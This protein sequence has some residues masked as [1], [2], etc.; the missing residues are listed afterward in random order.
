MKPTP[1]KTPAVS[2]PQGKPD[3]STEHLSD[4]AELSKEYLK[5]EA[6]EFSEEELSA[7]L[8]SL[9]HLS[10]QENTK[11]S[12][13]HAK[14]IEKI[15]I[16]AFGR[17]GLAIHRSQH[18]EGG[19]GAAR[20]ENTKFSAAH[21]SSHQG[22]EGIIVSQ[23]SNEITR[24]KAKEEER[25]G[26]EHVLKRA[27]DNLKKRLELA[28][29]RRLKNKAIRH[30]SDAC[31]AANPAKALKLIAKAEHEFEALGMAYSA[32]L[33]KAIGQHFN[34]CLNAGEKNKDGGPIPYWIWRNIR[35]YE[36]SMKEAAL[37]EH[38]KK[39]NEAELFWELKAAY[40][41]LDEAAI[42]PSSKI[43]WAA[44]EADCR[45]RSLD[46]YLYEAKI[47]VE[48]G[49]FLEA[50]DAYKKNLAEK[51]RER[52]TQDDYYR[53][54]AYLFAKGGVKFIEE[55][56]LAE[57]GNAYM[58]ASSTAREDGEMAKY[59]A[60]AGEIFL[61]AGGSES[62]PHYGLM[63]AITAYG[64]AV[65]YAPSQ[66]LRHAYLEKLDGIFLDLRNHL[67]NYSPDTVIEAY[68]NAIS[69]LEPG[70]DGLKAKYERKLP[71]YEAFAIDCYSID[72]ERLLSEKKINE[73]IKM[74]RDKANMF[75]SVGS[76]LACYERI[77]RLLSL[78]NDEFA[79]RLAKEKGIKS[80]F[81]RKKYL[82]EAWKE[83]V[84][85]GLGGFEEQAERHVRIGELYELAGDKHNAFSSY[86]SAI[87][88]YWNERQRQSIYSG[89]VHAA[90]YSF[91]KVES[92]ARRL[93]RLADPANKDTG[94]ARVASACM[95]STNIGSDERQY[96][97]KTACR[98]FEKA[99][100]YY[101]LAGQHIEASNSYQYAAA[102]AD[103]NE[104]EGLMLK[105]RNSLLM[106]ARSY[107][108]KADSLL[109]GQKPKEAGESLRNAMNCYLQLSFEEPDKKTVSVYY[110]K[111]EAHCFQTESYFEF[112]DK[113]YKEGTYAEP[114]AKTRGEMFQKCMV[115]LANAEWQS[116]SSGN[117]TKIAETYRSAASMFSTINEADLAEKCG[118]ESIQL[119]ELS[120][121]FGKA[122][123]ILNCANE[124]GLSEYV[125]TD[126]QS[127]KR[128]IFSLYAQE[129]EKR[130]G[131]GEFR[132]AATAY[133]KARNN[134]RMP[135]V[136]ARQE[137]L[138]F[139]CLVKAADSLS[140]EGKFVEAGDILSE[141][142]YEFNSTSINNQRVG[143]AA[144]LYENGNAYGQALFSYIQASSAYDAEVISKCSDLFWKF[145]EGY[146]GGKVKGW[147]NVEMGGK[148]AFLRIAEKSALP[149]VMRSKSYELASAEAEKEVHP[150]DPHGSASSYANAAAYKALAIEILPKAKSLAELLI[151]E[152]APIALCEKSLDCASRTGNR[153]SFIYQYDHSASARNFSIGV[154]FR[155]YQNMEP[156]EGAKAGSPDELLGMVGK[157]ASE[158][159]LSGNRRLMIA[160][161]TFLP[162]EEALKLPAEERD[163]VVKQKIAS[164]QL[165]EK[166][167][168]LIFDTYSEE[169]EN[170]KK[171]GRASRSACDI[172]GAIGLIEG[173]RRVLDLF[174]R[175]A[176]R[177]DAAL[178]ARMAIAASRIDRANGSH[179][180][181]KLISRKGTG[182]RRFD[183][184]AKK[185]VE[186]GY[187]SKGTANF[188]KTDRE[189]L[190]QLLA[191][192]PNEFNTTVDTLA[193]MDGFSPAKNQEKIFS[194]IR[195]IGA[196]TPK[197][198]ASYVKL[199]PAGR[200]ELVRKVETI[201]SKFFKNEPIGSILPE[202]DKGIL[203]E[204]VYIS[205]KP[206]GM[207]F[208][209]VESL[210][211]RVSDRTNDLS[212]YVFPQDGYSLSA[213]QKSY[214]LKE[215]ANLDFASFGRYISALTPELPKGE[216]RAKALRQAFVKVA[217][218]GTNYSPEE[219]STLMYPMARD[220]FVANFT[221]QEREMDSSSAYALLTEFKEVMGIYFKDN[222]SHRLASLLDKKPEIAEAVKKNL[223][224]PG[225]QAT[226]E[227]QLSLSEKPDWDAILKSNEQIADI[228]SKIIFSKAISPILAQAKSDMRKF[229]ESKET[230]GELGANI[231]AYLSKNQASFFA[232]ASAGVCTAQDT[233]LFNRSEHF[234]I[235]IIEN[236]SV[237]RGNIMAYVVEVNGEKSL[238]LRGFNPN[239][240]FVSQI[241]VGK[242]CEAV[243]DVARQFAKDN[244]LAH[245]YITEQTGWHPLSNRGEV[246]SYLTGRYAKEARRLDFA[247]PV[248]SGSSVNSIYLVA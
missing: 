3:L 148:D 30:Q 244:N 191:Q 131:N 146:R 85:R 196:P 230:K 156:K 140:K 206:V 242:F 86:S 106:A 81:N 227:K 89:G 245:V 10:K 198:F 45:S 155:A 143:L 158:A 189:F 193:G 21:S 168:D 142:G 61:R 100:D 49:R 6:A 92:I 232:K 23:Q 180:A 197:L 220:E 114:G 107:E 51:V 226:I 231:R 82:K 247:Y 95:L 219:V 177:K 194:A 164:S 207:S 129:A 54:A 40:G 8:R 13:K 223:S 83:Y 224:D 26:K 213:S 209:D 118:L 28:M 22:S 34:D 38:E 225:R 222:Y 93:E 24:E 233:G 88:E 135:S 11:I 108:E 179:M 17:F 97:S 139:D 125:K 64:R 202:E 121:E 115:F 46:A 190:R 35:N 36:V 243:L 15:V 102:S 133:L 137:E 116:S 58:K 172:L 239:T 39:H 200:A 161:Y 96:V 68:N 241:D 65:R 123:D 160:V 71:Q 236:E 171:L 187:L 176:G 185:L 20:Q 4:I 237:A 5:P 80:V 212:G 57:A 77:E 75:S 56:K 199:D 138:A 119:Y 184:L 47:L 174:I 27:G 117:F 87:S 163:S 205:Y 134:A 162:L 63:N 215:G 1:P 110:G 60:I 166:E 52:G 16:S 218:A 19:G 124:Y 228:L 66:E 136:R 235:N 67:P 73:A 32:G 201:K 29:E 99:G 53:T 33:C 70:S 217:R 144:G 59:A 84:D 192:Y 153:E 128:K 169:I 103:V 170:S 204:M 2:F 94:Y 69:K 79:A 41:K 234:H 101:G 50:A 31:Y 55:G 105:R 90:A 150:S 216:D 74:W 246:A 188:L 14:K 104:K 159:S 154:L 221:T 147:G 183:F 240:D 44:K 248:S 175:E 62:V 178:A 43:A 229:E 12:R 195:E 127:A 126:D 122:A 210:L 238:L 120:G 112:F 48:E 203:A 145:A 42:N 151:E 157:L 72:E 181:T 111:A 152:Q 7:N 186:S 130:L 18:S 208:S 214:V 9:W 37:P 132:E 165:G 167:L 98:L 149:S 109:A 91:A 173:N 113:L 76:R 25:K 182:E 211:Q 78:K 141:K